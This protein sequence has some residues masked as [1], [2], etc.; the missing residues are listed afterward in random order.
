M[1]SPKPRKRVPRPP[2]TRAEI[3]DGLRH[4]L[5]LIARYIER[6]E[7]VVGK[8][9]RVASFAELWLT[10]PT[11]IE[12]YARLEREGTVTVSELASKLVTGVVVRAAVEARDLLGWALRD[13]LE[14]NVARASDII[15]ADYRRLES[16]SPAKQ[17]RAT[18]EWRSRATK[19]LRIALSAVGP[20]HDE[21]N[22]A[23]DEFLTNRKKNKS[24][25]DGVIDPLA[26]AIRSQFNG[27]SGGPMRNLRQ[28]IRPGLPT[29]VGPVLSGAYLEV[30]AAFAEKEPGI[31]QPQRIERLVRA[32]LKK[33]KQPARTSVSRPRWA[34]GSSDHLLGASTDLKVP[35]T[36]D[37]RQASSNR[38]KKRRM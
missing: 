28:S 23:I 37:S 1:S 18:T 5:V 29:H 13:N 20:T 2:L 33:R 8:P 10:D 27:K 22:A 11:E 34:G 36:I 30:I 35:T 31:D 6:D 9:A 16:L 12:R 21:I 17:A 32:T 19:T 24:R 26:E 25:G 14:M 7:R 15:A 3:D 38:S 4:L